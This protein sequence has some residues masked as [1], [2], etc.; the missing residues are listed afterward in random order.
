MKQVML[1]D[2]FDRE[3]FSGGQEFLDM[4]MRV[5]ARI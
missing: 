4:E 2:E 1:F 5:I 3:V